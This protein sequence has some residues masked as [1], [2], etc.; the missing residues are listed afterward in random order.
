MLKGKNA[1]ITGARGGIGR[2][3]ITCFARNGANIWACARREDLVFI[4]D[5]EKLGEKYGVE[6][7]PLFFDV[8][9]YSQLRRAVSQIM[10]Q[11][12]SVDVLINVAGIIGDSTS[13]H[14]TSIDKMKKVME[15]NFF[16]ATVMNQY[17]SHLM[18][19]NNHGSIVNVASIAGLDGEPAQYEY[20]ASKAALIG[21]TRHL[22]RELAPWQ[23]RVNAVAPGMIETTMGGKIDKSL[24]EH[25]LSKMIIKRLGTADEVANV[26]AFLASDLSSYMTG[27]VIRVDGGI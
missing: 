13:F 5:M 10:R 14:M 3:T 2:A 7:W 18:V 9:D 6:I 21:A 12:I 19:K 27:Q 24:R 8:T 23:I 26:I 25:M 20:V 11:R 17:V 22:A 15:T 16:S 1:I 4:K